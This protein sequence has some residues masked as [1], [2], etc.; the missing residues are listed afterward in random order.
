M[1][2]EHKHVLRDQARK[3][4]ARMEVHPADFDHAADHFFT[5]IKPQPGCVIAGYWPKGREFDVIVILERAYKIGFS[6]TLPVVQSESKILKFYPWSPSCI[7][8]KGPYGILE[9]AARTEELLPDIL[10]VPLLAY[11]R[12][13][14][15]LGQGGGYYDATITALRAQKPIQAVGVAYASQAVLFNLPVEDHDQKLD[16]VITPHSAQR[17]EE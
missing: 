10:L 4:R 13:G 12:R 16:W 17:F 14:S 15:R 1:M 11:D 6:C 7:L 9:P 3:H 5:H 2:T 8:Q